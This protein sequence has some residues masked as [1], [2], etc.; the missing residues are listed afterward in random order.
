MKYPHTCRLCTN[1]KNFQ[2]IYVI[3]LYIMFNLSIKNMLTKMQYDSLKYK[4]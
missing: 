4:Q 2:P 3:I 1:K